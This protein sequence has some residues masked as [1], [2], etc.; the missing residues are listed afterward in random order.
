MNHTTAPEGL[1]L[2]NKPQDLTSF[3]TVHR[4]RKLLQVKKAGHA[5]TLDKFAT[6]LLLVCLG[7]STKLLQFLTGLSKTYTTDIAFGS[8]TNTDDPEGTVISQYPGEMLFDAIKEKASLFTGTIRQ[9]PPDYS[10]V[11]VDGTRAYKIALSNTEK[12]KLKEREVTIYSFNLHSFT[13]PYLTAEISCSTG[14]YIR[15]I[16][17][18][19]GQATG[20]FAHVHSLRRDRVGDFLLE[21]A[22]SLDEIEK[23]IYTL[24]KPFDIVKSMAAVEINEDYIDSLKK[25]KFPLYEWFTDFDK[26]SEN[27]YYKIHRNRELLAVLEKTGPRLKYKFVY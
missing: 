22:H 16:A 10:A 26:N 24:I 25:G 3:Q 18:D 17:R 6:G 23:G 14:T 21:D 27:G 11:H 1:L 13:S 2:V 8:Q 19:L 5:G 12:P 9:V 4:V 7:K 15:S 20:Y